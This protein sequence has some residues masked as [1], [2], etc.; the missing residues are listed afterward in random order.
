M[1]SFKLNQQQSQKFHPHETRKEKKKT[2]SFNHVTEKR[3]E[4]WDCI[5]KM[6]R[7]RET[8]LCLAL[9]SL[10][11]FAFWF[12]FL[13]IQT[14]QLF[15]FLSLSKRKKGRSL[16]CDSENEKWVSFFALCFVVVFRLWRLAW[17]TRHVCRWASQGFVFWFFGSFF[18]FF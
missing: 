5:S 2:K 14:K 1:L 7:R 12:M 9:S 6:K 18:I 11:T 3:I 16:C 15:L 13:A 4:L 8:F 10:E 17:H